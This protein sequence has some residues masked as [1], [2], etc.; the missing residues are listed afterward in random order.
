[1]DYDEI[2]A[3]IAKMNSIRTLISCAAN[4][5]WNLFQLDVK[6]AFL[7]EELQ[8][9]VYVDIPPGFATAQIVG[10]VCWLR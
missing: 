3:P 7:H 9:D 6:N 4:F 5:E 1:M 10:K 8:D 2:F